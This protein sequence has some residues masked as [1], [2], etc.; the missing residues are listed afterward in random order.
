MI[1]IQKRG[2]D[3]MKRNK[4]LLF[5]LN[6]LTFILE[7]LPW[8]AVLNFASPNEAPIRKTFSYFDLTPFGYAN[9]GPF[10]TAILTCALLVLL[11]ILCFKERAVLIKAG[12]ALSLIALVSSLSPLLYG[13]NYFSAVGAAIS[14]CISGQLILFVTSIRK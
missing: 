10:I 14:L 2:G 6:V 4:L 9:F 7:L 5:I 1:N 11:V 3:V 12:V 13:I 8:G